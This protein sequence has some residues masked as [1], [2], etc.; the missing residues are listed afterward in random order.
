[1]LNKLELAQQMLEVTYQADG[2]AGKGTGIEESLVLLTKWKNLSDDVKDEGA[3][4]S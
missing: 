4:K 2:I 3:G 1:M